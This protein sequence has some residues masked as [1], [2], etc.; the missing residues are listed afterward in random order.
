MDWSGLLPIRVIQPTGQIFPAHQ[1]WGLS[2]LPNPSR[3][4]SIVL[5]WSG[6]ISS[7]SN[8]WKS[9]Q[10]NGHPPAHRSSASSCKPS[11]LFVCYLVPD[12]IISVSRLDLFQRSGW[13]GNAMLAAIPISPNSDGFIYAY[14][15]PAPS[16][17]FAFH[18]SFSSWRHLLLLLQWWY[19]DDMSYS[20]TR[21]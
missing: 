20:L 5:T 11:F 2:L 10:R 18:C 17:L 4:E 1:S 12:E 14:Y 16:L 9:E 3:S 19:I 13:G 8:H 15:K 21:A 7:P 6:K